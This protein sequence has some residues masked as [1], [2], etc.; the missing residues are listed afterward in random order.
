MFDK[1]LNNYMLSTQRLVLFLR[2]FYKRGNNFLKEFI[3]VRKNIG[4][5]ILKK[6]SIV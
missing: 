4:V 1:Q 5:L 6:S 2:L 3:S